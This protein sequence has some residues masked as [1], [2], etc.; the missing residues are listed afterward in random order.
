MTNNVNPPPQLRIPDA[1][2]QNR[3][4]F[5]YFRQLNQI[6]FQLWVKTGGS[7]DPLTEADEEQGLSVGQVSGRVSALDD[8]IAQLEE[9]NVGTELN[10]RIAGVN[11]RIDELID[12]LIEEIQKI[13]PDLELEN[14]KLCLQ[15]EL[16]AELKLLNART[17]EVYET[18]IEADDI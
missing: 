17:E 5:G 2:A 16:L 11:A 18:D 7:Q 3:E 10:A 6:L 12:L 13:Q 9:S 14:K 1:F 8:R 15:V 4:Q